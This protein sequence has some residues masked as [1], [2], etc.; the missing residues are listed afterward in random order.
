MSQDA[1]GITSSALDGSDPLAC[2]TVD[3]FLAIVGAEAGANGLRVLAHGGVYLC[4]GILPRVRA[5]P[6]KLHADCIQHV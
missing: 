4:G 2:E 3:L 5:I 1:P 6:T